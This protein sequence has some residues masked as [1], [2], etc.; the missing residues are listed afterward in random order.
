MLYYSNFPQ[1]Q[2]Q[3]GQKTADVPTVTGEA[4]VE[5]T[6]YRKAAASTNA[7]DHCYSRSFNTRNHICPRNFYA[8]FLPNGA[9]L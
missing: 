2:C 4:M 6:T 9:S 3:Q 8:L 7:L 1:S 5:N